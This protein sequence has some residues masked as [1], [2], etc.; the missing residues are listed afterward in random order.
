MAKHLSIDQADQELLGRP[1]RQGGGERGG[2][3]SGKLLQPASALQAP[4]ARPAAEARMRASA[5]AQ[6]RTGLGHLTLSILLDLVFSR[7]RVT[8]SVMMRSSSCKARDTGR[9][10]RG[11]AKRLRVAARRGVA[12]ETPG[13]SGP[14]GG[15][16]LRA[17]PGA[18]AG[19]PRVD[20][21]AWSRRARRRPG[22][23]PLTCLDSDSPMVLMSSKNSRVR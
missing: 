4:R 23:S 15:W 14:R 16:G 21:G 19:A 11:G 18:R 2:T 12:S 22:R 13:R 8:S 7:R 6:A 1:L 17:P 20:V 5:A 3:L 9:A 10:K